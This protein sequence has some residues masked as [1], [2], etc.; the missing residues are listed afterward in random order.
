MC[1]LLFTWMHLESYEMLHLFSKFVHS[2]YFTWFMILSLF[3]INNGQN[4]HHPYL[5]I[6]KNLSQFFFCN[7]Y[8]QAV[9]DIIRTT[10][11]PRAMLKMLLDAGGGIVLFSQMYFVTFCIWDCL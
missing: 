5:H 7:T 4:I 6:N 9:A 1:F 3:F 2:F 11:G 10:L 8:L